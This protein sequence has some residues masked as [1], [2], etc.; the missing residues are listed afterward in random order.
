MRNHFSSLFSLNLNFSEHCF[1]LWQ[2]VFF[3]FLFFVSQFVICL[4]VV[5]VCTC[6]LFRLLFARHSVRCFLTANVCVLKYSFTKGWNWNEHE[7]SATV[8]WIE[9]NQK[10]KCSRSTILG[11]C[12]AF[13]LS[14]LHIFPQT[15]T[16]THRPALDVLTAAWVRRTISACLLFAFIVHHACRIRCSWFAHHVSRSLA[17]KIMYQGA[18]MV[19]SISH[20]K[21]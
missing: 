21:D 8:C 1:Y 4:L 20:R 3:V 18:Y 11:G 9:K 19:P 7:T 2:K 14:S 17:G 12:N 10:S 16:H 13:V 6:A 5:I 15:H